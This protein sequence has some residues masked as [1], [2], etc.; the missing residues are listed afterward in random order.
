MRTDDDAAVLVAER[1]PP[2]EVPTLALRGPSGGCIK[3][4]IIRAMA[5]QNDAV[6]ECYSALDNLL[7]TLHRE[8]KRISTWPIPPISKY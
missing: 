1:F 4:P 8:R 3:A 6:K 5:A 7:G 2:A